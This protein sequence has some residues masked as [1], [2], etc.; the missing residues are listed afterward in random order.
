MLEKK[1]ISETASIDLLISHLKIRKNFQLE[2]LSL[3]KILKTYSNI[4]SLHVE[5]GIY[6]SKIHDKHNNP[7]LNVSASVILTC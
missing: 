7:K 2:N 6:R 3:I 1:D 5:R 4:S